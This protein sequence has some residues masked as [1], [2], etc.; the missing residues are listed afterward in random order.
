MRLGVTEDHEIDNKVPRDIELP[1]RSLETNNNTDQMSH[2]NP[3][4]TRF[5][6]PE[7]HLIRNKD[8]PCGY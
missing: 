2:Y 4:N 8:S 3:L 5:G 1:A 6:V 7:L